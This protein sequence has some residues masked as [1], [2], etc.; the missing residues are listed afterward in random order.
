MA[1]LTSPSLGK[2]ITNVRNMLNQPN[3]SNSFWSDAELTEYLNEGCRIYFAEVTKNDEGL[4]TTTT[5]LDIA[6]NTQTVALPSDAFV[7]KAIWKKVPNGYE[8]LDYR[9]NLT[10]SYTTQGGTSST[11]YFPSY[12]FRGNNLV[13]LPT[14]N[15]AETSGLKLEY[16]QFPDVM[17]DAADTLTNQISPIFKQLIEAYA[18]FK[19]KMKESLVNNVD[20]TAIP[21]AQVGDLYGLFKDTIAN[22]S[23]NPTFI[24]PFNPELG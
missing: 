20:L 24:R 10:E 14:P 5:D 19:A 23:K 3:P 21:K 8:I 16:L 9:N 15:F 4:F 18:V 7:V 17:V 1:T 22:R 2:L 12:S 11:A 6:L 13:L